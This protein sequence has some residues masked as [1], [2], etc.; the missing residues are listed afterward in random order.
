MLR[1]HRSEPPVSLRSPFL[2]GSLPP[3]SACY[4]ITTN[5]P[6]TVRFSYSVPSYSCYALARCARVRLRS[7]N[8]VSVGLRP[9]SLHLLTS[10]A[11]PCALS[12]MARPRRLFATLTPLT[13]ST[14]VAAPFFGNYVSFIWGLYLAL[15]AQYLFASLPSYA[16]LQ[17]SVPPAL[18]LRTPSVPPWV[19]NPHQR[20]RTTTSCNH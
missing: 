20:K 13:L 9:Q 1:T 2:L 3:S 10:A 15:R 12:T 14:P 4:A 7:P 17:L 8:S 19:F 16:A 6:I 5:S 11:S 18:V